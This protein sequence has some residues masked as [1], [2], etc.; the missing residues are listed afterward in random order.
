MTDLKIKVLIAEDDCLIAEDIRKT[1]ED[2]GYSVVS[3]AATGK[4]VIKLSDSKK[5]DIILM[6]INL[7]GKMTGIDA[8]EIIHKSK[9]IPIIYI[10][11]LTDDESFLNAYTTKPVAYLTKPFRKVELL[12]KIDKTFKVA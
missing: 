3:V 12:K 1:L 7:K 5:P 9:N 8:A 6:D 4:D 10:T 11:G 2:N